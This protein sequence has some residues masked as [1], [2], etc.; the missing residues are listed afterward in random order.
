MSSSD[1][2]ATFGRNDSDEVVLMLKKL[3]HHAHP[4]D[5]ARKTRKPIVCEKCH[6]A[7]GARRDGGSCSCLSGGRDVKDLVRILFAFESLF[8][9]SWISQYEISTESV[10][11]RGV[12]D[13][14]VTSGGGGGLEWVV[15]PGNTNGEES[16]RLY[17][18]GMSGSRIVVRMAN[19][20]SS[21][22]H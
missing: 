2:H 18:A 11:Q 16:E 1:P 8:S 4:S 7:L 22:W 12:L 19:M 21:R 17:C 15:S 20:G 5:R 9:E 14:C 6:T 13:R 3:V 10:R